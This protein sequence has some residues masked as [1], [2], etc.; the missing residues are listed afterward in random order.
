MKLQP[1]FDYHWFCSI[2]IKQ[3]LCTQGFS[4]ENRRNKM[5]KPDQSVKVGLDRGCADLGEAWP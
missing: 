4:L 1:Y 2:K 3:K 5:I